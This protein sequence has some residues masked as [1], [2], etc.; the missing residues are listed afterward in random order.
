MAFYIDKI[1]VIGLVLPLQKGFE[2]SFGIFNA[3]ARVLVRITASADGQPFHGLGEA[4]I[5]FPFSPY[6][7]FDILHALET[8]PLQG[9]R[10]EDR[11]QTLDALVASSESLRCCPAAVCALNQ[12]FDDIEGQVRGIPSI[13]LYGAVRPLARCMQSIGITARPGDLCEQILLVVAAEHMPKP[14]VGAGLEQDAETIQVTEALARELGFRYLL[15]FNGAYT[16]ADFGSL[17]ERLASSNHLPRH[18]SAIEQP[19]TAEA[20][21]EG[22][23]GCSQ[24]LRSKRVEGAVIADE[25][26]LNGEDALACT[27]AGIGLNYKIQKLGGLLRAMTIEREVTR[28]VPCPPPS[29][30]GGTFPTAIGRAYDR[31]AARALATAVLPADGWLPATSYFDGDRDLKAI[32]DA[33]RQGARAAAV[34]PLQTVGVGI[35]LHEERVKKWAVPDF[36]A[37]YASVR[38]GLSAGKLLIDLRD[39]VYAEI[40]EELS[41]RPVTWNLA[42]VAA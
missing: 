39:K 35:A 38:A 34:G 20:G 29:L 42:E 16:P 25:S 21:V 40:Y 3:L 7:G 30:V 22:L 12:A 13:E 14:K 10:V 26:F 5:D 15:D 2:L 41:H 4:S 24:I 32:E 18:A 1:E 31:I 37:L 23:V 17:L 9:V 19:S 11:E 36:R 6:D 27:E 28:A 8:T 33:G